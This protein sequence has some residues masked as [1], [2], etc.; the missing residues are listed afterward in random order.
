MMADYTIQVA[1]LRELRVANWLAAEANVNRYPHPTADHD[2]LVRAELSRA[3][4]KC[5]PS[6]TTNA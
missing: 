4:A 6:H 3:Y 2:A 5:D 1:I